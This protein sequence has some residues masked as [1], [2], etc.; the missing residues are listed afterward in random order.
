[1]PKLFSPGQIGK[2]TV[3][4]R[5]VMTPMHLAYCPTGEVTD[6]IVEFYRLRAQGGVGLI[7]VGAVGI[8]PIRINRHGML[9]MYGDD[10]IPGLKRLTA[11]VHQSGAKIFSQLF[12]AGRYARTKE[13]G[14][15]AAVAPSAVPSRFT[16]ETP[17]ELTQQEIREI[18]GFFGKAAERAK[19][20]GFDGVEIVASAGY[21]ISQFLSPVTN[22]R[23][24]RYGGDLQGRM[25]FALEV[26]AAVREAVGAEFPI[27]VRIAGNEYIAGGNNNATAVE[28]GMA[29]EKAGVDAIN[30]T[31]GWHETL[32]P[33]ITMEVPPGAFCY[34]GAGFKKAR[35]SIPIVICNRIDAHLAERVVEN[36]DADFIGIARGFVADPELANKAANGDYHLIRPC[37]A[38]NQ[39]CMDN[40]FFGQSLS[41]LCNA[42]AGRETELIN[43]SLSLKI[44]SAHP[45]KILVI[46]AGAA[47]LEYARAAASKGNQVT[48]WEEKTQTGGQAHLAAAVPGRHD[49]LR[50]I[51]YLNNACLDLKVTIVLGKKATTEDILAYV[52]AERIDRVVIA[53]GAKIQETQIPIEEGAPVVQAWDVLQG[54]VTTGR[55]VV[56]VGGGA[57]GVET[58][59]LLAGEGTINAETLRFLMMHRAE[60]PEELYKLLTQGSK[61]ITVIETEKMLGRDIGPSTRWSMMSMLK[62]YH[63]MMLD[64]LKVIAITREGV[65]IQTSEM[66]KTIP[67]DTVILALGSRSNNALYHDLEGKIPKLI[68]IGDAVKPRKMQNAIWEAYNEAVHLP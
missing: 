59:L 14:G 31:G 3:K 30:V 40:I 43:S 44:T 32:I 34:L 7:I 24:D 37:I 55:D 67:A 58:A 28:F 49:F 63:V 13:Y 12:H 5:L 16:G 56:I 20:A 17:R 61:C 35:I 4:N 57:V 39:G 6:R 10:F 66:Q 11:A 42:E 65:I 47:G 46:G 8:D 27:M 38:C 50:L 41:C 22:E 33:Q 53:A 1:M 51:S 23:H 21:L 62:R 18:V 25:T 26:V 9:Q 68:I 52:Q 48:I 36:G 54:L 45:K 2:L 60:N 15:M 29:L 64:S 19:K